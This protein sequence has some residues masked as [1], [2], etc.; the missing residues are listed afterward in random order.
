[1]LFVGYKYVY[2]VAYAN[3]GQIL[4]TYTFVISI[5]NTN[6]QYTKFIQYVSGPNHAVDYDVNDNG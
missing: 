2:L 6:T 1:L 4:N 5:S 3:T